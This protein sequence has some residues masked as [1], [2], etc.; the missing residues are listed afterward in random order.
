MKAII[1]LTLFLTACGQS[2]PPAP[3]QHVLYQVMDKSFVAGQHGSGVGMSMKGH[4]GLHEQQHPRCVQAASAQ[5]RGRRCVHGSGEHRSV[6][7]SDCR[8]LPD[9]LEDFLER[10]FPIRCGALPEV[11]LDTVCWSVT[12]RDEHCGCFFPQ[13]LMAV[14]QKEFMDQN[15]PQDQHKIVSLVEKNL[16]VPKADLQQFI[17]KLNEDIAR[18]R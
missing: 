18:I 3:P 12:L 13:Y 10:H 11:N 17:D 5:S 4:L 6:L 16:V 8:G 14:G 1:C 15:Y 9:V 7:A 2:Q